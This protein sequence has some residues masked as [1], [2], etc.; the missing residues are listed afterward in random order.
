MVGLI[1][2]ALDFP[3][4][5]TKVYLESPKLAKNLDHGPGKVT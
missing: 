4:L 2:G 1:K 5:Y 3:L